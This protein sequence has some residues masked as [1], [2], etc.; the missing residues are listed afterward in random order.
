MIQIG[1]REP[2]NLMRREITFS[3]KISPPMK[4]ILIYV[5]L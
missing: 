4:A 1:V 5:I 2:I 3:C